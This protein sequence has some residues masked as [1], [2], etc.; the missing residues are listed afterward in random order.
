VGVVSLKFASYCYTVPTIRIVLADDHQVVRAGL[1]LLLSAEDDIEVVAEA[2]DVD[3]MLRAVL[4]HQPDVLV[5]ALTMAGTLTPLK[6]LP[7]VRERSAHTATVVLTMRD[8]AAFA[9]CAFRGGALGYVLKGATGE[10]FLDA[11]R[12]AARGQVYLNDALGAKLAVLVESP[13]APDNLSEREVAVLRLIALGH[14]N[15]EM[16]DQLYLSV[17]TVETHR[18]NLQH[19]LGRSTR[20]ELVSY[21][22]SHGGISRG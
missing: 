21:A 15:A 6:A 3:G 13:P 4:G 9:R 10:E 16:G 5:L 8:D 12:R 18:A 19:K 22:L 1:R 20:A 17:R 14:T 7:Q 11:V 2:G